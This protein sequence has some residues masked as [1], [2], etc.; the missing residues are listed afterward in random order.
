[1]SEEK[2]EARLRNFIDGL[3]KVDLFKAKYNET[4]RES[5]IDKYVVKVSSVLIVEADSAQKAYERVYDDLIPARLDG[6]ENWNSESTFL[7]VYDYSSGRWITDD[8]WR[9][10]A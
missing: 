6:D 8:K 3:K 4:N 5:Q 1:M 7:A 9:K 2:Q 10:N